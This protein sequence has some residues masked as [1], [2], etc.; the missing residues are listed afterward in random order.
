MRGFGWVLGRRDRS[1]SAGGP[2]APVD[3]RLPAQLRRR[4]PGRGGENN[5]DRLLRVTA[6]YDPDKF[7]PLRPVN[8]LTVEPELVAAQPGQ[9]LLADKHYYGH[10]FER[11][12]G[13]LGLR[14]VRPARKGE[15][16]RAGAG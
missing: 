7:L 8:L 13:E 4:P 1:A 2:A 3:R 11:L 10:E 9:V 6:T 16:E 12:L 5:Y 15:A 14:L